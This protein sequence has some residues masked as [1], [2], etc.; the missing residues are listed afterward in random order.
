M[1]APDTAADSTATHGAQQAARRRARQARTRALTL[2]WLAYAS[3]YL[4]RKGLSVAKAALSQAA[5]VSTPQLALIDTAFLAAYAVGQVPS[6]VLADRFGARRVIAFGLLASAAACV[7]FGSASSAAMFALCFAFNGLSQSTGWP[8]TT[9]AVA[10]HTTVADRGRVMGVWATCYQVGGIAATALAAF[11]LGRHGWR[12]VFQLPA[13]WLACVAAVVW[14]WLPGAREHGATAREPGAGVQADPAS[15]AAPG[16]SLSALLRSPRVLSYG[17]CYF[18]IKLIRYSLLFWLPFYLHTVAG[19]GQVQSG[20]LSTSFELG[21]VLGTIAL[22][23]LSDRSARP[24]SSLALGS[25]GALA[26]ALLLYA[27]L[28]LG[29]AL[30][31]FAVMALI[32]ALLY[33][34]DALLSGAA[35]QDAG[36]PHAAATAV[37]MVNGMGSVGAL[38][39]GAVTVGVQQALGWNALFYVFVGLSLLACLFLLPALRTEHALGSARNAR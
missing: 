17:A 38:L 11:L 33:G 32:G 27:R 21:G 22:G 10:E 15:S 29:S 12:A 36:G 26:L 7:A 34:P 24:R 31:H 16:A 13:I 23:Y 30:L 20:Y 18:C 8:G 28:P 37:G 2:S 35:A 9:K 6:G 39:Q 1:T 25:L 4:G 3:Y 19:F 5:S 14:L